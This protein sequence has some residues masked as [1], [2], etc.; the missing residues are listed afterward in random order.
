M[1]QIFLFFIASQ[2]AMETIQIPIKGISGFIPTTAGSGE[3]KINVAAWNI[4][5]GGG[6]SG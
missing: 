1:E 4:P 6:G 2:M 5:Q 3:A